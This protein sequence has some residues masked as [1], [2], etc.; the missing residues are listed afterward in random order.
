MTNPYSKGHFFLLTIGAAVIALAASGLS[1]QATVNVSFPIEELGSCRDQQECKLYCEVPANWEQCWRWE[2]LE[3]PAVL[4]AQDPEQTYVISG[5]EFTPAEAEEHC[6]PGNGNELACL[7]AARAA[8]IDIQE[9]LPE[10]YGEA[11]QEAGITSDVSQD[12]YAL[13]TTAVESYQAADDDEREHFEQ[14][15]LDRLPEQHFSHHAPGFAVIRRLRELAAAS[16]DLSLAEAANDI[17][18]AKAYCEQHEDACYAAAKEA[19]VP[20]SKLVRG[21]PPVFI[22]IISEKLALSANATPAEVR[23]AWTALSPELKGTL[24]QDYAR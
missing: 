20:T 23:E 2:H 6:A 4:A 5:K 19:G 7:A 11:L 15:A 24:I 8:G 13:V 10:E 12:P 9:H 1:A 16:G 3:Q 14:L 17:A 21:V 18:S 22:D